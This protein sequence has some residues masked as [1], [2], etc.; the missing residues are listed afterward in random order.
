MSNLP[1]GGAADHQSRVIENEKSDAKYSHIF[2][3]TH[4]QKLYLQLSIEYPNLY[5]EWLYHFTMVLIQC[6]ND[7]GYNDSNNSVGKEVILL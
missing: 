1:V 4:N 6:Q 3:Y 2:S 5:T 7:D